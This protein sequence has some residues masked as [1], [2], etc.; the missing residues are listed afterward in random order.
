MIT[1]ERVKELLG[2]TSTDY[3]TQIDL[4]I[5]IVENDVR[6]IMNYDY[7]DVCKTVV[8]SGETTFKSASSIPIGKV[9]EGGDNYV[10]SVSYSAGYY[11]ATVNEAFTDDATELT[12]SVNIAQ[13][14]AIAR[15]VF[16]R[17]SKMNTKQNDEKVISKSMGPVSYTFANDINKT[18]G[19]PQKIIDDLGTPYL[20]FV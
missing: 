13:L 19:Y 1:K 11:T 9:I 12:L 20:Q 4:M 18:Y 16:Y 14:P 2:I 10:K 7:L 3:D 15:M 6:R 8:T 5:P 17:V